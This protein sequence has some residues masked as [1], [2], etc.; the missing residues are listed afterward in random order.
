LVGSV[1]VVA[2]ALLLCIF[3]VEAASHAVHSERAS[4]AREKVAGAADA[5]FDIFLDRL[6]RAESDGRDFLANPRSTALGPF[7]FIKGTFLE[8]TRRHFVAETASLTEEQILAL[9][10]NRAFS[11]RAVAVYLREAA[12]FL[13]GQGFEPTFAHLRLAYLVGPSGAVR[14][15]QAAS[16]TPVSEILAPGALKANPFMA[17]MT[18]ADLIAKAARD[19]SRDGDGS[20]PAPRGRAT[21]AGPAPRIA[22]GLQTRMSEKAKCNV[23]LP[24]CRRWIALRAQKPRVAESRG[25]DK[26]QQRKKA[27]G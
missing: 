16:E 27:K 25:P 11:R 10:T 26:T 14:V 13:G 2:A 4:L 5:R 3:T 17:G 21:V 23:K 9:R 7:Q 18:A 12:V 8:V 15:M 6:M 20:A 19:V 24:S 1:R 22:P